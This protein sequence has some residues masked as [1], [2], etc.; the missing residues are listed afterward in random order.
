MSISDMIEISEVTDKAISENLHRRLKEENIYTNIGR[1]LISVNPFKE[2]RIYDKDAIELYAGKKLGSS[3]ISSNP[4]K[5][6]IPS[7]RDRASRCSTARLTG[8][9]SVSGGA[10]GKF[11][12]F[13]GPKPPHIYEVANNMLVNMMI[14]GDNQ[15]VIISGE[16]GAGKTVSA[17]HVMNFLAKVSDEGSTKVEHVKDTILQSNPLLEAFGNAKTVM[18]NNSSRFG[19]FMEIQYNERGQPDGGKISTFLLEKSRVVSLA[20]GERNYHIFYQLLAGLTPEEM[21]ELSLGLS[22]PDKY[23]YLNTTGVYTI[24]GTD[25]ASDFAITMNAMKAIG[26]PTHNINSVLKVVTAILHLGNIT[27]NEED[28]V[29]VPVDE[30]LL[31]KPASLL[32]I[33]KTLLKEKITSYDM[34]SRW[35]GQ[36]EITKKTFNRE[37]ACA[38]RDSLSKSLYFQTFEYLVEAVNSTM[39]KTE[40]SLYIGVLDIYGFECFQKNGF[41]QF[42]INY[43]NEKLQNLFIDFTLKTEQEEYTEEGISWSSI[44]Y[45][46]NDVVC[47]LIESRRPPGIMSVLDDVCSTMHAVSEGSENTLMD[48]LRGAITSNNNFSRFFQAQSRHFS[49]THYAGKV[50]YEATGFCEKNKDSISNDLIRLIKSS[51]NEFI[52]TLFPDISGETATGRKTKANTGSA[53]I[54]TQAIAL[55]D[56]IRKCTPHYIRCVKPSESKTPLDWDDKKV[57]HQ[58]HYLGL[59]ENIKVRRAGFAFRRE[60]DRIIQRYRILAPEIVGNCVQDQI[61]ACKVILE[62]GKLD[63]KRYQVGKTKLFLKDQQMISQLE[64]CRVAILSKFAISIQTRYR[65]YRARKKYEELIK[66]HREMEKQKQIEMEREKQRQMELQDKQQEQLQHGSE[67]AQNDTSLP[68]VPVTQHH[69]SAMEVFK[70]FKEL[71]SA[72]FSSCGGEVITRG[73]YVKMPENPSEKKPQTITILVCE[74]TSD[75]KVALTDTESALSD[76]IAISSANKHF[77]NPIEITIPLTKKPKDYENIWKF[78]RWTSCPPNEVKEWSDKLSAVG[79]PDTRTAVFTGENAR[80]FSDRCGM[81]C[82]MGKGTDMELEPVKRIAQRRDMISKGS[83]HIPQGCDLIS[84]GSDRISQGC[85]HTSTPSVQSSSHL[86]KTTTKKKGLFKTIKSTFGRAFGSKKLQDNNLETLSQSCSCSSYES[87]S[88]YTDEDSDGST[89]SKGPTLQPQSLVRG[90]SSKLNQLQNKSSP[91]LQ[92]SPAPTPPCGRPPPPPPPPPPGN[93]IPKA[94]QAPQGQESTSRPPPP[95][96][97]PNPGNKLPGSSG[98]E[99]PRQ[100]PPPPPPPPVK[101]ASPTT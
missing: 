65:G 5:I 30:K 6:L 91:P 40:Q 37:Q 68:N 15:C 92:S 16:S 60:F 61:K 55:V 50:T 93:K 49:I 9:S 52:S 70:D 81:F 62:A 97:P 56:K 83:D 18:N 73:I 86:V 28:N 27:F 59:V 10:T 1:V 22:T 66:R 51:N 8:L 7:R 79:E 74:N 20:D 42:S 23:R 41:E 100:P 78:V 44:K 14:E 17:K 12:N 87:C 75:Y 47:E 98:Q 99:T 63:M 39:A 2:I 33:D 53:K 101:L 76:L 90:K 67:E 31:E 46:S 48:K 45:F 13:K 43:V 64:D 4:E 3:A 85:D 84:K 96:P 24:K 89:S 77:K 38:A 94:P 29:A 25:D 34:E 88:S 58:V 69:N 80:F 57:L 82:L 54:R 32:E 95:P 21:E 72:T 35:G 26:I 71:I 36:V 11:K 19:K